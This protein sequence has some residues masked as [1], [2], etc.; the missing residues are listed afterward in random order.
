M[1]SD[2]HRDTS[3]KLTLPI[4]AISGNEDS[5]APAEDMKEWRH[6]T[7]G[8][9]ASRRVSGGHFFAFQNDPEIYQ[10]ISDYLN[11]L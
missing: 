6:Y 8:S 2:Y 10:V 1:F 4:L 11:S 7:T 9:F 5:H 3:E